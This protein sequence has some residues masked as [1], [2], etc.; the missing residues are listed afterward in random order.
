MEPPLVFSR[1]LV[2]QIFP[3]QALPILLRRLV[4]FSVVIVF[5]KKMDTNCAIFCSFHSSLCLVL[6]EL[7]FSYPYVKESKSVYL[8]HHIINPRISKVRFAGFKVAKSQ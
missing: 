4:V 3:T 7:L 1:L 2:E 5:V 8:L 6:Y